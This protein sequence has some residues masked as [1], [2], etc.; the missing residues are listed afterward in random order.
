MIDQRP[1]HAKIVGQCLTVWPE[2][3]VNMA[4]LLAILMKAN[5]DAAVAV[6]LS[7][8]TGRARQDAMNAAAEAT[9]GPEDLGLF[10]A[11]MLVYRA[12]EGQRNDIAHGNWGICDKIEDGVIW[13]ESKHYSHWLISE[14]RR[15]EMD[16]SEYGELARHL[17]VYKKNDFSDTLSII[18]DVRRILA[19]FMW[20][21][22]RD[23][24]HD[25]V[26]S[27]VL[28]LQLCIQPRIAQAIAQMQTKKNSS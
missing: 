21:L 16:V 9:L 12:A 2:V 13:V 24:M 18:S 1:E 14:L 6:Y 17:F 20:Y 3:E 23:Q 5:S 27:D 22:R 19:D 25:G 11:I 26:P 28:F 7:L 8:R 4:L 10:G 15:D